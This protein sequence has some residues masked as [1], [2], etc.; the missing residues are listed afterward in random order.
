M[1]VRIT[2]VLM[3]A[4]FLSVAAIQPCLSASDLNTVTHFDIPAGPLPSALLKFSAQSGVQVTS[5]SE[6]VDRKRSNGVIGDLP[7]GKALSRLL[8]GT[9]LD[10]DTVDHN[11]VSIRRDARATTPSTPGDEPGTYIRS[12]SASPPAAPQIDS[13]Q[14]SAPGAE[15]KL[16]TALEEI[17][18]TARRREENIERVPVTINV[19]TND[20]LTTL[21]VHNVSDL[22]EIVTGLKSTFAVDRGDPIFGLR[23]QSFT[24]GTAFPAVVP[25]FA[26]VP[27]QRLS[28]GQFFDLENI[29]VLKGPQGTLFGRV[30]DGGAI[31]LS[32]V[33]PGD[34][35]DGYAQVKLGDYDLK[36]FEGAV[37]LPIIADHVSLRLAGSF[38]RREGY[39][40]D[41]FNGR[42][43]DNL[44]SE[45]ARVSL[46]I[47]ATDSIENY[48]IVDFS[49]A[50]TNGSAVIM[51]A[52][53]PLDLPP[54]PCCN[55]ATMAAE[56]A[57]QQAL[58]PRTTVQGMQGA[59][60]G[61]RDGI[62][63]KRESVWAI[64]T[65][66]WD[67]ATSF[68]LKNIFGYQY[69]KE[70]ASTDIDGIGGLGFALDLLPSPQYYRNQY[71]DELQ[72]QGDLFNGRLNYVA[73][74]YLEWGSPPGPNEQLAWIDSGAI[75]SATS[76]YAY[77]S[78]RAIYGQIAFQI[79]D[80]LRL[81]LGLRGTWDKTHT[82]IVQYFTPLDPL[83]TI[84]HG[85]C[86]TSGATLQPGV[87]LRTPCT[88]FRNSSNVPTYTLGLD[89]QITPDIFAYASLRKGYRPSGINGTVS[90]AIPAPG[91][92]PETDVS[93]ELGIKATYGAAPVQLRSNLAVY[94]DVFKDI[95]R[96][97]LV[98]PS[99]P[100]VAA[101]AAIV[102]A[103]R[104]T[105][106]GGEIEQTALLFGALT[107]RVNWAYVDAKYDVNSF[108]YTPAQLA[109]ACPANPVTQLADP[110]RLCPYNP[111]P[112][113]A[114]NT[115]DASVD[116]KLPLGRDI[117]DVHV[118]TG[119]Y[120]SSPTYVQG[121]DVASGTIP[122]FTIYNAHA[123]WNAVMQRPLD[124]TFFVTNLT[125]KTYPDA[126][127]LG[128]ELGGFGE[129]GLY[130]APPRMWGV[131]ARY[132]FGK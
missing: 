132:R 101:Y 2:N 44:S 129:K 49:H 130:Y 107:L 115:V 58:G 79:V 78:S 116:Y 50:A 10:Y 55:P 120:Y 29:Q 81:N 124:I 127:S 27:L 121:Q 57:Q 8:M 123:S 96:S 106:R 97:L 22:T 21:G 72:A 113:T 6:L 14:G 131:S 41:L 68:K 30:T 52:I 25:Y 26:E 92:L 118:A 94:Y 24:P 112:L 3:A 95:Q 89:Y 5:P 71:T 74:S 48:T 100:T 53:N 77:T 65:T 83:H 28:D 12:A 119:L 111:L 4:I 66:S 45:A 40:K 90:N 103:P 75:S 42:D 98:V 86:L 19:V 18:V 32:P 62:F 7:A 47:K 1:V 38:V 39:T 88:E 67:V 70:F 43:L 91:Y 35:F 63:Y 20:Q 128:I 84:P 104:A 73:G 117:G 17:V 99:D 87:L 46:L 16:D 23:G 76:T 15:A 93:H 105:I 11:T 36:D 82:N 34:T 122:A 125:N 31:L 51:D 110:S 56:L 69:N 102:N 61:P 108:H 64:N 114:K 13:G 80:R 126:I 9:Q 109:G 54:L 85:E 60:F 59:L 37:N 33:K